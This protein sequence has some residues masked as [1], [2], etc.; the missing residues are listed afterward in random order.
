MNQAPATLKRVPA[1]SL[2]GPAMLLAASRRVAQWDRHALRPAIAQTE[3]LLAHCRMAAETEIGRTHDLGRIRSHDEFRRRVPLRTY[4]DYEPLLERMRAGARDVLWPGFIPYYGCSS[5]SSSTAAQHKFLPV[6]LEQIAWQQKAGF[7]VVARYLT[8]TG[9]RGF[10]GGYSLG[11]FP[12]AILKPQGAVLVGS[13]PGIMLRHLPAAA[14]FLSLPRAPVRDIED[15]DQKLDAIA[16]SYLDHDVR[17]MSGTTCWFSIL[18]D[19]VLA[20]ARARGR[21]VAHI[22]EIWPE[23]RVLFG[24][25]VHA[26]PYRQVIEE[27]VGRPLV[28]MDNY[29]AT[30]GGIFAVTDRLHDDGM[31]MLPDRGVFYEFVPRA[32]YG[33]PGATRLPLWEVETGQDYVVAVSTSS[34]LFAY[35]LGDLVRFVSTFPHRIRFTGRLSGMLS[36]TQ[37]LTSALEIEQAF[38]AAVA[39][40]PASVIDFA[41]SAEVGVDGTSKGRYLLLAEFDRP[42]AD[43][44]AFAAAFDRALCQ[45]NRVYREHRSKEVA[46]LPPRLVALRPG[47]TRSLMRALGQDSVQNKFPRIV[48]ERRRDLLAALGVDIMGGQT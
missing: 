46:I 10:T 3:T 16:A 37:E 30:E 35:V 9:D 11:L 48:D 43:P 38:S 33:R 2:T 45:L 18:F 6:S 20:A 32:E 1:S 22:A 8:M 39:E 4:A 31:L 15:Y 17:A 40:H 29:N 23:L 34:G 12:P 36:V 7:D 47:A 25:G 44:A 19:R 41:A 5:G 26:E 42:P 28:L 13:N 27:R 14:R 24:G 21:K